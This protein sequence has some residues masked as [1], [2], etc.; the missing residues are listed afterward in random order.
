MRTTQVNGSRSEEKP[1]SR[2]ALDLQYPPFTIAEPVTAIA[3]ITTTRTTSGKT[4]APADDTFALISNQKLLAMYAAMLCCR[5]M[6]QNVGGIERPKRAA[7]NFS[8]L[9][10]HEAAAVGAAIDLLPGDTVAAPHWPEAALRAINP[11]VMLVSKVSFAGNSNGTNRGIRDVTLLFAAGE[12]SAQA[13]WRNVLN[14]HASEPLPV[15]LFSLISASVAGFD[16]AFP[17]RSEGSKEYALPSMTV[18]GC[19]A[20]AVYR[21]T[22]EA[23]AHARRGNGPTL[24][25][26]LVEKARDPL[27]DMAQYLVRKG[28]LNERSMLELEA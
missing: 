12:R 26:C 9:H 22:S 8:P 7:R 24:I 11:S 14:R 2:I 20:V 15:L 5:K 10:G 21:V 25:E 3:N 13:A 4:S 19:D 16:G 23:I 28:L 27:R 17:K 6:S 18:D 1:R